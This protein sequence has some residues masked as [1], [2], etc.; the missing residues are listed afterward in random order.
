MYTKIKVKNEVFKG[1]VL[2]LILFSFSF[3]F[4]LNIFSKSMEAPTTFKIEIID[5]DDTDLS[6]KAVDA[7]RGLSGV[8]IVKNASDVRYIIKKGFGEKFVRGEF[9]GLIEVDRSSF[10]QG[11]SLLNDRIVTKLVGD[12]IYLDLYDRINEVKSVSYLEYSKSLEKTRLT[13]EILLVNV[14][15][16]KIDDKTSSDI[17]F[18]SYTALIFMLVL[19]MN[20]GIEQILRINT[21]RKNGLMDRLKLSGINEIIVVLS[22]LLTSG[23]KCLA[24]ILPFLLIGLKIKIFLII[25]SLFCLNFSLN[26]FFE[27]IFGS[28]GMFVFIARSIMISMLILGLV[29]NFYL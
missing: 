19:C 29:L 8:E 2:I 11:I 13:N 6:D 14:N 18:L 28:K 4:V 10:K 5:E 7:I 17:N 26:I 12:Y 24:V 23:I 22:E 15:D 1:S 3:A 27:R 16:S 25:V 21:L 20:I 9:D